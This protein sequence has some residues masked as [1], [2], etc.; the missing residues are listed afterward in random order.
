MV[1]R[2]AGKGFARPRLPERPFRALPSMRRPDAP[3]RR[4]AHPSGIP[5]AVLAGDPRAVGVWSR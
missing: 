1:V 4:V 2:G 5:V 3:S